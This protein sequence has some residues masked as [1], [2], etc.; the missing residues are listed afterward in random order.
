M[1]DPDVVGH[2]NIWS[3]VPFGFNHLDMSDIAD[4]SLTI[5][6]L[7][8]KDGKLLEGSRAHR[9]PDWGNSWVAVQWHLTKIIQHFS[10]D[11][12]GEM[13]TLNLVVK[14][15]FVLSIRAILL[16]WLKSIKISTAM[17]VL[18]DSQKFCTI[19]PEYSRIIGCFWRQRHSRLISCRNYPS[20]MLS[21]EGVVRTKWTKTCPP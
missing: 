21:G 7:N 5:K 9:H 8:D 16:N 14:D 17:L 15:K 2:P 13:T 1:L 12:L 3:L 4:E 20:E 18:A 6:N 19:C 10:S 11:W